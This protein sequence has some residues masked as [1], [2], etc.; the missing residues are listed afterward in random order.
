MKT[1][2]FK[3][4]H[5]Y[6][7]QMYDVEQ[8]VICPDKSAALLVNAGVGEIETE[9]KEKKSAGRKARSKADD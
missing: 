8:K 6:G 2:V 9:K 4:P 5:N 7:G 3:K 1:F